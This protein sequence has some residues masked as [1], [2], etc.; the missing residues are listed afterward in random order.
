MGQPALE[1]QGGC[2]HCGAA[3]DE[4]CKRGCPC[5]EADYADEAATPVVLPVAVERG[6]G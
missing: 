5:D 4:F 3:E 2:W 1:C 6:Q